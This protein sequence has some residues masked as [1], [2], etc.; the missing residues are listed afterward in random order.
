MKKKPKPPRSYWPRDLSTKAFA[1]GERR[2]RQRGQAER[3]AVEDELEGVWNGY[4]EDEH[5][6]RPG[7]R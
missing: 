6:G 2:S 4:E 1:S 3:K 5:E 7:H